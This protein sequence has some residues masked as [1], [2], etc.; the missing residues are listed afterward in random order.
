MQ[1]WAPKKDAWSSQIHD[2]NKATELQV[3]LDDVCIASASWKEHV[4]MLGRFFKL[5]IGAR[6]KLKGNKCL[7][8]GNKVLFLKHEICYE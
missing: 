2:D 8:G 6:L 4:E 7:L 1:P 3:Y 5:I